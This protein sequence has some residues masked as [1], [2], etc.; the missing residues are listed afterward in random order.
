MES[1]VYSPRVPQFSMWDLSPGRFIQSPSLLLI[2]GLL[3]MIPVK[4][5]VM[6]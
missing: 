5:I 4:R 2:Y 6:D 3:F 1:E